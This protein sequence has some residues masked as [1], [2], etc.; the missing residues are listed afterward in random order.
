MSAVDA[1]SL[2]ECCCQVAFNEG[3][4]WRRESARASLSRRPNTQLQ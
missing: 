4:E 1:S 3:A 2:R